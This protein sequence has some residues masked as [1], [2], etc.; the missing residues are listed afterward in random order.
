MSGIVPCYTTSPTRCGLCGT[1]LT[2]PR[3]P[4]PC[5]PMMLLSE[6]IS[7]RRLLLF[8]SSQ[9]ISG[10]WCRLWNDAARHVGT[11]TY[12]LTPALLKSTPHPP[13]EG[14][15]ASARRWKFILARAA[16]ATYCV[17]A[18]TTFGPWRF[19]HTAEHHCLCLSKVYRLS[20]FRSIS[21]FIGHH[22][23]LS[24]TRISTRLASGGESPCRSRVFPQ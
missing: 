8:S 12:T 19:M 9:A 16:S 3:R 6:V 7:A 14:N 21:C 23:P 20:R 24:T 22:P 11:S 1:T 17:V 18:P 10:N 4:P 13:A 15:A 5:R 2:R